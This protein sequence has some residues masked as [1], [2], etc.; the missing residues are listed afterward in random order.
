MGFTT[1]FSILMTL[2]TALAIFLMLASSIFSLFYYSHQRTSQQ[3][4]EVAA[5]I[6]QALLVQSP[7]NIKFW[8]PAMMKSAGIVVLEVRNADSVLYSARLPEADDV[9]RYIYCD[10]QI[11][12]MH[13]LDMVAAVTYLNPVLGMPHFLMSTL[14]VFL[15]IGL[16]VLVLYLSICWLRRQT[17]GQEE[18]EERARR[19]LNGERESVMHG[20]VREW[21]INASG[22]IDQLLSDLTAAREERSRVDALIRAFAAQDAQTGLSNRL[23]FDNQLTTQL[24]DIED[25]GTHGIVMMI[26]V[27]DFET[28]QEM[29]GYH[30]TIQEYRNTL[31]NLLSTFVMR[32]P[33]A[34]LARYYN[35]DFTVLLPHRTLKDADSIA[36]QLVKAIDILPV[37][38]LIDREDILHIGICAYRSGQSSEQVMESVEDATRNAV[39]QGGNGWCVFDRQVPDKGRGSVKWRT[40]LELTLARGGPRLYQKPAVTRHGVVHHREM[41]S[42]IYDGAQELLAAEYMPLVQQLG[43]TASYDRQ[44][45]VRTLE[46]SVSWPEETLAM[47]VSVDSLLQKPFIRWLQDTLLQCPKQQRQRILFELAEANVCQYIGRL[48]PALNLVLGL[49]CRLAVTQAGLTLVSTTYIKS[50]PVEI[51]KLHP[52]LVRSLERRPENQLF[53]QSL[54]EACKGTQTMVFAAGVRT[55]EEWQTLLE[56]GVYGGQGDFFAASRSVG[57]ELK[58]YSPR[59]RV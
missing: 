5:S 43:L 12:L 2:L 37:T 51:I 3:L 13:H 15:S 50:L 10:T 16:I 27:P 52:G 30:G 32:Y 4:R 21:P 46:L 8:L 31:V 34:L 29:H 20:S 28:L 48:R 26:R 25:V 58:K 54:T 56:K 17:A 57:D 36:A 1:R 23:F 11:A 47:P 7:E 6:D 19:I 35:N 59:Y 42:R 41:M 44:L 38:P 53:V 55:K 40:L 24:E 33:G 45:I 14:S 49:G 18:L 39:L 22:A 9:H